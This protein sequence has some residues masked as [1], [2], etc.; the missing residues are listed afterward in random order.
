M[1]EDMNRALLQLVEQMK[2][3]QAQTA[4]QIKQLQA[5]FVDA[6]QKQ[7]SETEKRLQVLQEEI[8]TIKSASGT[9]PK[10]VLTPPESN[11]QQL[12]DVPAVSGIGSRATTSTT[13]QKAFQSERL[14]D[15]PIFTGKKK[16]LIPFLTQ[17]RYK[18]EGNEDRFP[19]PRSRFLY[20]QTRIGGDA[21]T[22]LDPL[23]DKDITTVAQLVQFLE[24]SYGDPNRKAS[25]LARLSTLKQ[26]K[27]NFVSHFTEFRRI[28]ADSE[29]NETGLI[30]QLRASLNQELQ[31]AMVGSL[32]PDSL[33]D[34]ANQIAR[35]DND[36]RY[37][38][39][40]PQQIR[41]DTTSDPDAMDLDSSDYAPV[42][43]KERERRRRKGLCYKCGKKGHLSPE[44]A[45]P[46]PRTQRPREVNAIKEGNPRSRSRP[47][48]RR[49]RRSS[50]SSS[51]S[52]GSR[53]SKG[54][55]RN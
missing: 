17:L 49:S 25:A 7:S 9:P 26:G 3:A 48:S 19:T 46:I 42:G 6:L 13:T 5:S 39:H 22:V 29:L 12:L 11:D 30:M 28:A 32:I 24:T 44:C 55:S 1:A 23:Y 38:N 52:A 37:I 8:A 14:P 15:P 35:F 16:D 10:V 53:Q 50:A 43:S 31:R 47:R 36:L 45:K 51:A 41:T 27:R 34:Y 20:A 18:L 21:A 40:H 33:N 4:E 54:R 2:Q